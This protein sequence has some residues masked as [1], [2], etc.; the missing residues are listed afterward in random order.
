MFTHGCRGRGL[1]VGGFLEHFPYILWDRILS[2]NLEFTISAKPTGHIFHGPSCLYFPSVTTVAPDPAPFFHGFWNPNS[3]PH[4]CVA[5][6][7]QTKAC[8]QPIIQLFLDGPTFLMFSYDPVYVHIFPE[9]CLFQ[10][11]CHLPQS[12]FPRLFALLSHVVILGLTTGQF[13]S[14][15]NK[16]GPVDAVQW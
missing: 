15:L 3:G 6:I 5:S 1:T 11:C 4:G 7:L 10:D 13:Q 2:L 16:I 12:S 14:R 8:P 9:S